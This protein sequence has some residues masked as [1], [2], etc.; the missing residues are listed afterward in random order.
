[1]GD[2]REAILLAAYTA[3]VLRL[4]TAKRPGIAKRIGWY[5]FR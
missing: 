5:S 2:E 3:E 1:M 4:P